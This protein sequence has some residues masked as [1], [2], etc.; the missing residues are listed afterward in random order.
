M[1]DNQQR[2][3]IDTNVLV[4]AFTATA[5]YYDQARAALSQLEAQDAQMWIS[6]QVIREHIATLSRPQ[7]YTSPLSA[8]VI[9][10]QIEAVLRNFKIADD[11]AEVT[12]HLLA[13]IK[14][15]PIG[16]KQIH[17]A[18]IVATMQAN[19]IDTLLTNNVGDFNRFSDVI[20]ILPLPDNA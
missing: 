1:S 8:E 9:T 11:T 6:R 17:D 12:T 7:S 5:P 19:K 2:V 10:G 14:K 16:G 3:F 15:Y 13:L 18:N 4:Y 20:T